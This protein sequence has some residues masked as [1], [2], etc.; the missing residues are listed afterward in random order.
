MPLNLEKLLRP[1]EKLIWSAGTRIG[2]MAVILVASVFSAF[3][4]LKDFLAPGALIPVALFFTLVPVVIILTTPV[5]VALTSQRVIQLYA[6][7]INSLEWKSDLKFEKRHI[8]G[9]LPVRAIYFPDESFALSH[10]S[11]ENQDELF[12]QLKERTKLV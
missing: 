12:D 11:K 5:K 1:D 4:F 7:R 3:L 9:R 8:G 2:W 6:F 10:L